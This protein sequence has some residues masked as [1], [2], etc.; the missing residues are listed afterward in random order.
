MLK[1]LNQPITANKV[2]VIADCEHDFTQRLPQWLNIE[3]NQL[4]V[5]SSTNASVTQPYGCLVRN[6]ILAIYEKGIDQIYLIAPEEQAS[7]TFNQQIL[8]NK[9]ENDGI[10]QELIDTLEYSRIINKDVLTWLKG[11]DGDVD[12]VLKSSVT[13]LENHPLIPK[14]VII[15]AFTVNTITGHFTS[16][17][18]K[19]T[20]EDIC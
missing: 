13:L 17:S 15:E 6:I 2:L 9:F 20:E 10:D 8:L 3:S 4:L 19:K 7:P 11:P 14:R 1:R 5:L 16:I 18:S 12:D